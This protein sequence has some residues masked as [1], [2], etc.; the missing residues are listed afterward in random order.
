[1]RV[2]VASTAGAGHFGPLRP[3]IDALLARGDEVLVV[4]PPGLAATVTALHVPHVIGADPPQPELAALWQRFAQCPPD[5]AAV[6]ANREIFGRL[7]TAAM[8]PAVRSAVRDWTPDL[9]V[10]E[11]CEYASAVVAEQAG[12]AHL[13]VA[14]GLARVEAS[15]LTL[16]EPVL[17]GYRPGLTR[18]L[19]DTAYLTRL[20]QSA[21]PSPF[22]DTRRYWVP[23]PG[24]P[25]ALANWWGSARGPLVYL[26]FGTVAGGL[27]GATRLYRVAL[28]ATRGLQVRVLL[29]TGRGVD[30]AALGPVPAHV[31]VRDWVPQ[32]DVLA[33]ADAVVCHGGSGT[34][35]GALGAGVP[36]VVL[37]MFADQP[38]NAR[39]VAAAGAG[40][41]VAQSSVGERRAPA[42]NGFTAQDAPRIR[43]ALQQVLAD[44]S[45]RR[46]AGRVG[47]QMRAAPTLAEVLALP[48]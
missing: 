47:A 31:C 41:V 45:Y 5:E 20:P 48:L 3:V 9:V 17:E 27:A 34:T 46:A 26:T 37:P 32:D 38:A 13:Q 16:V 6:I 21:D 44:G 1:M 4:A 14:I 43:A 30:P 35:F 39:L 24:H 2:L 12:I 33:V 42:G 18:R 7:G 23:P 25:A 29:T 40:V 10:R 28:E 8:L 19:L 11:P 36:L 15:A 22:P